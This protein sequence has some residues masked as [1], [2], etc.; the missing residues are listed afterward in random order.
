MDHNSRPQQSWMK[1]SF[2]SSVI[3]ET[4]SPTQFN[5]SEFFIPGWKGEGL[6]TASAIVIKNTLSN[7]SIDAQ[8]LFKKSCSINKSMKLQ[9]Y[10]EFMHFAEYAKLDKSLLGQH[11]DFWLHF[12]DESSP[13]KKHIDDFLKVHCFRAVAIYLFRIKFIMDLAKEQRL[14]VTED[15]LMNPLSFLGKIFVKDSSTELLCD[16]LQINQYSWYRPTLEYKDSLLK[17]KD[18]FENVT[19]TELIKLISTPKDDKIYSIRN[20]SH[21]LSHLT[22]GLLVNELLIKFP[23][24]L[25]PESKKKTFAGEKVCILPKT[26]NTRFVGNHVSSM[27]LSHWLAQETNVKISQWNNLICP[28]F[29]GSEFIDGQFLKI[30]QELQFL[31]FLTRIAAEHR[32]E[33][34]PF[35]CKIMREKY[36]QDPVDGLGQASFFNLGELPSGDT[37]Y[38][39]IVLNLTELPKTNPHHFLVQ[40]ILAQKAM[41]KKDAMVYVFT[42]QKLFVPSQSERV[43]QLLKDFKVEAAINME[44]LKGKGEIAHFAYI[45]TRRTAEPVANKHLFEVSRKT[46]ESCLSFEFKGNLTRFNKFNKL[47]EELQSFIKHKNPITTPIFVSEVEKDIF[48]EFH[49]DAIIGGKLVSSV[50]NKESGHL[51]HPS[52]FKN[53]T[54]SSTSLDTFFAIE[55]I[56][57]E[58]F[59]QGKRSLSSELLG[60]KFGPE[61]QFP[62]LL[63][64]NQND[65]MDIRIELTPID[66]YRGK[67]EQYGTAFYHYF[68]LTPKHPAINLNVFREYFSSMLGHQIIQLQLSDGPTKLK[69]KLRSLLVPSFFAKAHF[70]PERTKHAFS[71]LDL[72]AREIKN[73]HPLDLKQRFEVLKGQLA[74]EAAEYPWHLLSLLSHFKLQMKSLVEELEDGKPQ[75]FNFGNS[76][77]SSELVKL[78][79]Y[80]IYPKNDDVYVEYKIKSNQ[81]LQL[82]LSSLHI[83]T[84]DDSTVLIFKFQDKDIIHLHANAPMI[85]FI[86]FILQ[87]A[88]GIKIADIL[89]NL[90]IPSSHDLEMATNKFEDLKSTKIALLKDTEELIAG[91]LR[92]EV[93]R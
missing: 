22:F 53:L 44:E 13:L 55:Q 57:P 15:V 51:P 38:N 12:Q 73:L 80:A 74:R 16:S 87:G 63:I 48:F 88:V 82:P 17:L 64:V 36:K 41:L 43:E 4:A 52:F 5:P 59:T 37:L 66:A 49:Q 40:Q 83:K 62:L 8:A 42:N 47:V 14:V 27:A 60:L 3:D 91:I 32:Y 24:W 71:L 65:P 79:T 18:A 69:A 6:I 1:D 77:I 93:S 33:I 68:G 54:K 90:R 78:K 45:L 20:Y 30:C 35:I 7:L 28:E 72:E 50:S 31:S 61:K 9:T 70:M 11:Q 76:L 23:T 34:V 86:K 58:D 39:R 10:H 56:V 29:E 75:S 84:T 26:I 85:H 89:L 67:L 21:S 25:K 19:L 2:S 46:K 92:T 81:D